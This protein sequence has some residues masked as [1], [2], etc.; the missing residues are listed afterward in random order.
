VPASPPGPGPCSSWAA[1]TRPPS[2]WCYARPGIGTITLALLFGL[3]NLIV[4]TWVLIQGIELRR[5]GKTP[6]PS[7]RRKARPRTALSQA[8]GGRQDGDVRAFRPP[9]FAKRALAMLPL[10]GRHSRAAVP[11]RQHLADRCELRRVHPLRAAAPQHGGVTPL[12]LPVQRGQRLP[13]ARAVGP[14]L[15][16][17]HIPIRRLGPH[18]GQHARTS[19]CS[20]PART[21]GIAFL[22][23]VGGFIFGLLAAA[24][25]PGGTGRTP[26]AMA[27]RGVAPATEVRNQPRIRY[28]QY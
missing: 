22:A 25:G 26:G 8:A 13:G 2:A 28:S 15:D 7:A 6:N 16:H 4:G 24:P 12:V 1:W 10:S 19:G 9:R 20:T 11:D 18:P 17:R 3:F 27:L 21:G 5:T 14:Q 23:H